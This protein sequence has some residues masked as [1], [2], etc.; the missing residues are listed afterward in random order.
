MDLEQA[1]T[2]LRRKHRSRHRDWLTWLLLALHTVMALLHVVPSLVYSTRPTSSV[3][4]VYLMQVGP[5]WVA[6][7]GLTSLLLAAAVYTGR[8]R[9]WAHLA[10]AAAWLMYSSALWYG[11]IAT[12]GP[13]VSAII[14]AAVC[15]VHT[16]VAASYAD[17]PRRR[18]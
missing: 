10:C 6:V 8:M 14:T 11:A 1:A 9:H 18:P 3:V 12:S 4:V 15:G 2:E 7:F 17:D 5:T 16:L 13:V